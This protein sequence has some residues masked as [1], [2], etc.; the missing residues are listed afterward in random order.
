MIALILGILGAL[1][2]IALMLVPFIIT[3]IKKKRQLGKT[4]AGPLSATLQIAGKELSCRHC[5]QNK[6][7]KR[8]GILVT[9]WVAL[10]HFQFWN[11]SAACYTCIRCGGVEWFVLPKEDKVQ[12]ERH[13][14]I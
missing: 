13:P 11:Q 7:Q 1:L 10:F 4:W 6:F 8:E 12:I 14:T 5:G 9:S 3:A 2:P